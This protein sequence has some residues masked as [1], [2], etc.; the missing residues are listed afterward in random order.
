[1]RFII[2]ES[3]IEL[4]AVRSAGAGGQNVNKV[5]SAVHLRFDIWAS[6]LPEDVKERLLCLRDSRITDE[7][8]LILK[9]QQHRTQEQ[10]RFDATQ[11][12]A[13]LIQKALVKPKI[14]RPTHPGVTAKAARLGDKKQR[15]AIKRTRRYNPDEWE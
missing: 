4:S 12:L 9:A 1:M 15:G 10:N 7:G 3:E 13:D 11:R 8:V 6:S 14:R 2:P 5:S